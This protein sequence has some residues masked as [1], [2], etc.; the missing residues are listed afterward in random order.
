LINSNINPDLICL[1]LYGHMTVLLNDLRASIN[2]TP[3]MLKTE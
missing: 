1:T 3:I 2:E